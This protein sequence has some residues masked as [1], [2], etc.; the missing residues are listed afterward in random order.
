MT[1]ETLHDCHYCGRKNFT[2]RGI[3]AHVCRPDKN[4]P[5]FPSMPKETTH[6]LVPAIRSFTELELTG[7]PTGGADAAIGA[8]L[9]ELYNDAQAAE[10]AILRFGAAFWAVEQGINGT[11][12]V[13]S[14]KAGA[15]AYGFK[16]WMADHAPEINERTARRYRDIAE[17]TAEKF[18]IADPVRVFSLPFAELDQDDQKKRAAVVDFIANKSM[19]GLQLELGIGGR[20]GSPTRGRSDGQDS[21]PTVKTDAPPS[22]CN[23][24]QKRVWATL[25]EDQRNSYCE[26]MPRI[27][28]M[29]SQVADPK[30]GF[31]PNLPQIAKDDLV[32]VCV[33][34]LV[35]LRPGVLRSSQIPT[36]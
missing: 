12:A 24:I 7:T 18:M 22:W 25:T 27:Y 34:L 2:A 1:A 9:T 26:W 30:K 35:F 6:Q 23:E 21:I 17:A 13:N 33:E 15:G 5:E 20:G 10:L 19:R 11:R 28:M 4:T 31:L 8:K 32:T 14:P 29:A 3:K 16:N 36:A